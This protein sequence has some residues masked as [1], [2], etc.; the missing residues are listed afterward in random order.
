[1][2]IAR[3]QAEVRYGAYRRL[4]SG[5]QPNS[6]FLEVVS[7]LKGLITF[8][9]EVAE[10]GLR[11]AAAYRRR[12]RN[13][14]SKVALREALKAASVSV[15][16]LFTE[17]SRAVS[18]TSVDLR[19]SQVMAIKQVVDHLAPAY[20][21]QRALFD[22][23]MREA[24]ARPQPSHK[25]RRSR[26]RRTRQASS[27]SDTKTLAALAEYHCQQMILEPLAVRAAA[28][29]A[30]TSPASVS[31]FFE[32]HFGSHAG[33]KRLCQEGEGAIRGS[34]ERLHHGRQRGLRLVGDVADPGR[35]S[36]ESDEVK[37]R[38]YFSDP[39][40]SLPGKTLRNR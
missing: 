20:R 30:K 28:R 36:S 17:A 35:V 24:L 15:D 16:E 6:V 27:D 7:L 37:Q 29:L 18:S 13:P 40:R 9:Q 25:C 19:A 2:E 4:A 38:D 11:F 1:V 3:L 39:R 31:R 32:R 34:L 10:Y 21:K 23:A 5:A 26:R 8:D 14:W 22:V 33:Y 12:Y